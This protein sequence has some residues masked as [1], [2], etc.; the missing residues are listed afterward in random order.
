MKATVQFLDAVKSRHSIPSDYALAPM[1]GITRAQVS[2]LRHGKDFFSDVTAMKVA[3]LLEID[4]GIVVASAHAE[5]AK[6]EGEK[7]LWRSVIDR[8]GGVAACLLIG[9]ATLASPPP[10]QA[11]PV[12]QQGLCIM[13]TVRRR[14]AWRGL[15]VF[16]FL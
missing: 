10:A 4:A 5:R 9:V 11:A 12:A 13:S 14:L 15:P 2:R 8:L 6:S 3:G 1:L 16:S 7:A